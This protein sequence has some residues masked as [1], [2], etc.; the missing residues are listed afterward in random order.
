MPRH[1]TVH[2][3]TTLDREARSCSRCDRTRFDVCPSLGYQRRPS[4]QSPGYLSDILEC[5]YGLWRGITQRI[6]VTR[7]SNFNQSRVQ[8]N[9]S[10]TGLSHPVFSK[11]S[12]GRLCVRASRPSHLARLSLSQLS[13]STVARAVSAVRGQGR[14]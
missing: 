1:R 5:R 2:G 7:K 6:F 9:L 12:R 10:D 8:T 13:T 11:R 3:N 14:T 4:R